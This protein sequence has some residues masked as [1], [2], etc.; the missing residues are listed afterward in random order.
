VEESLLRRWLGLASIRIQSAGRTAGDD[1]TASR[2]AVPILQRSDVNR[3]L[4]ELLPEAAPV[5]R[6]LAP[7][8]V[9]RRRMVRRGILRAAPLILVA[10][11]VLWAL[12]RPATPAAL[13][14]VPLAALAGL[15]GY[16]SLGHARRGGF[17][18]ARQGAVIRVTTV[19]PVAK[20]QSGSVR[21]S[22]F[23][24]RVGLATLHVDVAGGGP[25]PKVLEEAEPTAEA[26][27]QAVI[28]RSAPSP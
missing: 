1:Q 14:G 26:L 13:L 25:T 22:F 23:Q 3:V 9:A 15:A 18:Y 10:G 5:P 8:P 21:S 6:L 24:R 27:L 16:R 4:G 17:L 28:G 19:V 12:V 2:L 11:A 7:P 20:A